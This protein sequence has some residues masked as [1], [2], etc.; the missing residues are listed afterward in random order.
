MNGTMQSRNLTSSEISRDAL[1]VSKMLQGR[2][3]IR[4]GLVSAFEVPQKRSQ[5]TV[6]SFYPFLESLSR[7]NRRLAEFEVQTA[8]QIAIG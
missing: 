2:G 8:T 3:Q 7:R 5:Q 4:L 1:L 6:G